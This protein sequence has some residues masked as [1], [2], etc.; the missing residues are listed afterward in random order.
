MARS[1]CVGCR[2]AN[3]DRNKSGALHPSGHGKCGWHTTVLIAESARH[4]ENLGHRGGVLT[5]KGGTIWRGDDGPSKCLVR[6][7]ENVDHL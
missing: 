4:P 3:W 7:D 1:I 2:H 5:L 6:S